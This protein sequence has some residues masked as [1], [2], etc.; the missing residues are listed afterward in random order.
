MS[1]YTKSLLSSRRFG[2]RLPLAQLCACASK[3]SCGHTLSEFYPY[4]SI[5]FG[6][7]VSFYPFSAMNK[8][9]ISIGIH[10]ND[11]HGICHTLRGSPLDPSWGTAAHV[12]R[13][14]SRS[15]STLRPLLLVPSAPSHD[16][17]RGWRSQRFHRSQVCEMP[18][19][20]G[21]LLINL[22]HSNVAHASWETLS[23]VE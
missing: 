5:P 22:Q 8:Y 11:P 6:I 21:V 4:F 3:F 17:G 1:L 14:R 18:I 12:D 13:L 19:P 7:T 23:Q 2:V 16:F 15:R 10:W 20:F 9:I